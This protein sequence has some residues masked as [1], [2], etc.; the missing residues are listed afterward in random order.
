MKSAPP[1]QIPGSTPASVYHCVSYLWLFLVHG[2]HSPNLL[3][4][5]DMRDGSNDAL[6]LKAWSF[7]KM[8][9][10][11]PG[12]GVKNVMLKRVFG[13]F[14]SCR[15]TR[16]KNVMFKTGFRG[17]QE[18]VYARKRQHRIYACRSWRDASL[19][20]THDAPASVEVCR[21][22]WKKG[23][24]D[25]IIGNFAKSC[26]RLITVQ[27]HDHC[28][29]ICVRIFKRFADS[30]RAL[31]LA[32]GWTCRFFSR[33]EGKFVGGV[34]S[35]MLHSVVCILSNIF[36]FEFY[37]SWFSVKFEHCLCS[38]STVTWKIDL[39][40]DV[41]VGQFWLKTPIDVCTLL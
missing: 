22:F 9:A 34:K 13:V 39:L 36:G 38:K 11:F 10:S 16:V 33:V 31:K 5:L 7:Q 29:V 21:F 14:C 40:D 32:Q 15:V 27:R 23:S 26:F 6:W 28:A 24:R 19:G 3:S 25:V 30:Q 35:K 37:F 18:S 12:E 41:K 2:A 1:L 20:T 4:D 17:F 8:F